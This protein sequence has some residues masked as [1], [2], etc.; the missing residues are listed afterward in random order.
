MAGLDSLLAQARLF[1]V[2]FAWACGCAALHLA[3]ASVLRPARFPR[4]ARL[5]GSQMLSL[6]NQVVAA[7]HAMTLFV[8][9]VLHLAPRISPAEA[10]VLLIPIRSVSPMEASEAFWCCAMVGYLL[11]DMVVVVHGREGLDMLG[12]FPVFAIAARLP[13]LTR[14]RYPFCLSQPTTRSAWCHGAHCGSSTTAASTS[15]GCIWPR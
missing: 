12:E 1:D 10:G 8:A 7:T 9:A 2:S 5:S 6:H 14:V 3:A 11:Y 13:V 4:L 15:S